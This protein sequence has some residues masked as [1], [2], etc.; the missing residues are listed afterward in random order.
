MDRTTTL[1]E[2]YSKKR[3]IR[4]FDFDALYH[5]PLRN[6]ITDTDVAGLH[7]LATSAKYGGMSKNDKIGLMKKILEPRGFKCNTTGT[8]RAVFRY[9]DD[10][11]FIIKVAMDEIGCKDNPDEQF[12]QQILKPFVPKVFDVTP[13]GTVQMVEAVSPILNRYEFEL[14]AA[15][16]FDILQNFFLGRYVLED[17][18]TDFFKNWGIRD[19]FGP[20][21]L[22]YPYLYEIDGSKLNCTKVFPDGTHCTGEIDY[23]NGLNTVVCEKC[24][25]R[26][27]AKDMG[28]NNGALSV[29]D[30]KE[31]VA[32]M[33]NFKVGTIIN[34]VYHDLNQGSD[35]ISPSRKKNTNKEISVHVVLANREPKQEEVKAPVVE[36]SKVTEVKKEEIPA[37][38]TEEQVASVILPT[39]EVEEPKKEEEQKGPT[40]KELMLMKQFIADKAKAFR[41]D[42]FP[43]S[44]QAKRV[45]LIDFLYGCGVNKYDVTGNNDK[46]IENTVTEYV[47]ANY[48]FISEEEESKLKAEELAAKY[49]GDGED[50]YAGTEKMSNKRNV[51]D[52]L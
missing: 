42:L 52:D 37:I 14:I 3:L 36:P 43:I 12:N 4:N 40:T 26:Y 20:V 30:K 31:V 49:M 45:A 11:S 41:H 25:Q 33:E 27:A 35:F 2:I 5:A 23:D 24:G 47:D 51:R 10:R 19:G 18:G 7:Y 8:N 22:D 9:E 44:T 1:K 13:C 46:L 28:A 39:S 38:I 21:L 16:I 32:T 15:E 48:T 17:I 50:F 34:G 29:K 6:Y